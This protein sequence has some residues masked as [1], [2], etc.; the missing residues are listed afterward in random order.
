MIVEIIQMKKTVKPEFAQIRTNIA[1]NP[2]N[3]FH[4]HGLVMEK[5]V[6]KDP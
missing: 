5:E 4:A 2:E 1:A 3:A 6:R